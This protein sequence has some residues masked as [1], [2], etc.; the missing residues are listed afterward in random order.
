MLLCT[1]VDLAQWIVYSQTLGHNCSSPS[2]DVVA[3]HI[4]RGPGCVQ[5]ETTPLMSLAAVCN[6]GDVMYQSYSSTNCTAG[7]EHGALVPSPSLNDCFGPSDNE[8][9]ARVIN[10]T[11]CYTTDDIPS[12]DEVVLPHISPMRLRYAMAVLIVQMHVVCVCVCACV[13]VCDSVSV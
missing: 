6:L 12:G 8:S 11:V 1:V 3:V 10:T 7:T 9:V 5:L 4:A 13:C 2:N